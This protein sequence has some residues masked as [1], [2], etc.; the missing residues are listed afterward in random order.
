[1]DGNKAITATFTINTYTLTVNSGGNGSV[2]KSPDQPTYDHGTVVQLTAVPA[3]GYHLLSWSGGATG[4]TNP[5]NV[6]MDGNKTITATFEINSY[7]LTTTTTG[8]GTLTRNPDLATYTHGQ[9]VQL[10]AAPIDG[11]H[12]FVEWTHAA[13]GQGT[14]NPITVVMNSALHVGAT[15][16]LTETEPPVATVTYPNGGDLL[17]VGQT[18]VLTW[19]A[20]D[21]LFVVAID[22][23]LSRNGPA[24]PFEAIDTV[25]N[26]GSYNWLVTQP[27]TNNAY[28]KIVA[29]D[30]NVNSGTDI[31]DASF[32][33]LAHT[34]GVEGGMP[35]AFDLAPVYPNPA[36]GPARI[37][38]D[39]P[40]QA[41][42]RVSIVDVQGREV[43]VLDESMRS[44]GRHVAIWDGRTRSGGRASAGV[45]FARF[46]AAGQRFSRRFAFT[47]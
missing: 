18:A 8:G 38:Y 43:A 1:M 45:Y 6:T 36:T 20:T 39:V 37:A 32:S 33:I 47:R 46:E 30:A 26:T 22:I 31:S 12:H 5:L 15:F 25:S 27:A 16:T 23:F 40:R 41:R 34:A 13:L 9:S 28:I 29:R 11:N 21:N 10:I 24:G 3:T 14:R 44:P 35:H 42:V 2:T 19:E 4:S 7:V 17:A